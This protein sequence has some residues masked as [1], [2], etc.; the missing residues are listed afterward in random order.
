MT[1]S[2]EPSV[3]A[4]STARPRPSHHPS[5]KRLE[6]RIETL[7]HQSEINKQLYQYLK[8]LQLIAAASATVLAAASAPALWTATDAAIVVVLEGVQQLY[9]FHERW[10][11]YRTTCET[12]R[13]EETLFL[14]RA[15]PYTKDE[16]SLPLLAT[17]LE[18]I[19]AGEVGRFH[20]WEARPA[21][22]S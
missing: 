22:T 9:H 21:A 17:R 1:S 13:K 15:T 11:S 3:S 10:L 4:G 19:L 5:W 16:E 8:L 20:A 6:E 7:D 18:R 2:D 14:A 12:L